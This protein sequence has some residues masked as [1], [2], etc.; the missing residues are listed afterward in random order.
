MKTILADEIYIIQFSLGTLLEVIDIASLF[1]NLC[2]S[3]KLWLMQPFPDLWIFI[4]N[5]SYR[6]GVTGNLSV[7]AL[8]F[9]QLK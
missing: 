4:T 3:E 6:Q 2:D 8:R 1:N 9:D 5:V 7:G